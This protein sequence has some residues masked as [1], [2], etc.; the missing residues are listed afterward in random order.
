MEDTYLY[1]PAEFPKPPVQVNHISS[2]FD[3]TEERVIV[4]A[5]TTFTVLTDK[6]DE[7]IL[8]AKNLEI[9]TIHQNSRPLQYTYLNN[10]ITI[11]LLRPLSKGAVFKIV[12]NSICRPTANIL[13]GIYFDVTPAG[14][15]KTMITQ[16]QQW[17]FQRICPCVDDMRAK[18]TWITRIIADTRYT[19]LISNG[20][21]ASERTRFDET[22]DTITY[23]NDEPMPRICSS[24]VWEPGIHSP[25]ISSIRMEKR[26]G[27]NFLR[28]KVRTN[29]TQIMLLKSWLT[30]SSGHIFTQVP[31][32]MML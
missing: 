21:I 19:N 7:L 8:N 20:N 16:C 9:Q 30:V 10:L 14:L 22:R 4:F 13:E 15:P 11:K 31:S 1:H 18:C 3:I 25:V 5:E 28:Q 32:G 24:S 6:L 27:W 12:T 2:T 17:G 26:S 29:Q 23:R